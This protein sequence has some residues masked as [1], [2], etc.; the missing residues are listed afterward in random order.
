[1]NKQKLIRITT[2]P[3]SLEKLLEGQLGFMNDHFEVTAISSEKERLEKYGKA[4]RISTFYV[5]MTRKITPIK[6]L[7][8]VWKLYHFLKK[9]KPAIVHT[10]TPKAGIVGMLASYLARVPNRLH[11]IA[12]LPLLEAKGIKRKVLNRVEK[13]TYSLAT[14]VYP[15]SKGLF[16]IILTK[17]FVT[18][19]KMKIIGNGSSNGIDTNYFSPTHFSKTQNIQKRKELGIPINEFIFVFVGRLVADKGINELVEAFNSLNSSLPN[20]LPIPIGTTLVLVGPEE[21]E[22]DPLSDKTKKTIL[23][24]PKIITTGYQE[25]VRPFFAMSNALVFPSY[26]EGFPNVVMQ[27]GA[28]GLPSIVSNINGCNEIIEDNY[29]GLIIPVKDKEA[30]YNAMLLLLN[31]KQLTEKLT[32]NSRKSIVRRYQRQTIWDAILEEYLNL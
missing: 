6:D 14:K 12:G 31:E 17:N 9:I 16:D 7:Q 19:N 11:T 23:E 26:R 27:A 24:N 18:P 15:N 30:L 22:L 3:I 29:N 4:E 13:F 21:E 8:A 10:H 25:D 5:E 28:M 2:V 32:S 1:M 20:P